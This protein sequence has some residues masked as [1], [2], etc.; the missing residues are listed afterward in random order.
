[1]A[2]DEAADPG[3]RDDYR[4]TAVGLALNLF[5]GVGK[6]AAGFL[7]GSGALIAD[8]LHSLSDL[9]SDLAVFFGLAAAGL[10]EDANH[11]YGHHKFSSLARLV[12]GVLLLG[13]SVW[14]AVSAFS[15]LLAADARVPSPIA[16]VVAFLSLLAKEALFR[17]TRAV[18]R[19]RRSDLL[20]ANAWHHRSDAF[21]SLA[22]CV[23][24][25]AIALGGPAW[26]VLDPA[27][28]LVL[29]AW[30]IREGFRIARGA[31]DDLLDAAPGREMIE[32]LREHILPIE[33]ARAYHDFRARKVG[34]FFELDLHLQVDPDLTVEEGH[35]IAKEV[36][37]EILRTHPEVIRALVHL[38][39][40]TGEHLKRKGVSGAE[41]P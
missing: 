27:I 37:R 16:A 33:G 36:K 22:V 30:L 8:G 21:S 18:A 41:S 7:T 11:P 29:G 40:A 17:W 10:P 34:D 2:P 38:E 13:L 1:M 23:A 24:L 15:H 35:E 28:T 9:A 6:S 19:R 25:V 32:D 4:V 39:P 31:A 26:A 14:L 5:L 12:V 3:R 20:M